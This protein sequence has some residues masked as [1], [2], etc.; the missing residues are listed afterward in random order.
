MWEGGCIWVKASQPLPMRGQ[1]SVH[2]I[3]Y[4]NK[5]FTSIRC[6]DCNLYDVCLNVPFP[7][8][9]LQLIG[10]RYIKVCLDHFKL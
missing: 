7:Q 6:I 2:A 3:I 4:K 5:I 8:L 10:L 9:T 1:S